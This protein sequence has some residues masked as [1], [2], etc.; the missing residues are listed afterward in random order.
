MKNTYKGTPEHKFIARLDESM[1]S[2]A[3]IAISFNKVSGDI[4]KR[5]IK[6]SFIP[7]IASVLPMPGPNAKIP[8]VNFGY[9]TNGDNINQ[10]LL[11]DNVSVNVGDAISSSGTAEGI[12]KFKNDRFI[13]VEV[14]KDKFLKSETIGGDTIQSVYSNIVNAG[15]MIPDYT[16]NTD[17][18]T[19]SKPQKFKVIV[20]TID[21]V[22]ESKLAAVGLTLEMLQ[23]IQRQYGEDGKQLI[24]DLLNDVLISFTEEKFIQFAKK[25]A[26]QKSDID[27]AVTQGN[28]T[29]IEASTK[30]ILQRINLDIGSI[31]TDTHISG[32]YF[33][34]A[35]SNVV[36]G[37]KT[38]TTIRPYQGGVNS[39]IVGVLSNGAILVEDGYS[40]EDYI[41]TGI[42]PTKGKNTSGSSV[43]YNPYTI[44][45]IQTVDGE[46]LSEVFAILSRSDINRNPLDTGTVDGESDF[47]RYTIV[48]NA[49]ALLNAD[50]S[51]NSNY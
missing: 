48:Q 24:K 30:A 20:N 9:E 1:N 33:V 8:A 51:V 3:D 23:D 11:M 39:S 25:I 5:A 28:T 43:I 14:T 19:K 6:E 15:A 10:L 21:A 49:G 7:H 12:V 26:T 18:E 32:S 17:L 16:D 27:L 46:D 13:L 22:A 34:I 2:S 42:A 38:T 4:L 35:S 41:L 31:G 29:S 47:L 44:D 45:F 40:L 37:L 36:A 50:G